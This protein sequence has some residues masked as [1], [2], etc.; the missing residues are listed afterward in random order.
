MTREKVAER[1]RLPEITLSSSLA[2]EMR[3]RVKYMI[4]RFLWLRAKTHTLHRSKLHNCKRRAVCV[5]IKNNKKP[6]RYCGEHI[7]ANTH[8][9]RR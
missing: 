8:A 4:T 1:H 9:S 2:T 5:Q 7:F 6:P 3:E